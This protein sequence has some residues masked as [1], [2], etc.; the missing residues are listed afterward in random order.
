[1]TKKRK[2]RIRKLNVRHK[3]KAQNANFCF[4]IQKK[5]NVVGQN[6]GS[7]NKSDKKERKKKAKMNA[8]AYWHQLH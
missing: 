4:Q 2:E 5:K 6:C 1:M 8:F 3:I 7:T